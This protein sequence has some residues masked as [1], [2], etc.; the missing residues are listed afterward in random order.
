MHAA[1]IEPLVS[2]NGD[3]DRHDQHQQSEFLPA[4]SQMNCMNNEQLDIIGRR[5]R[6]EAMKV[7]NSVHIDKAWCDSAQDCCNH[8]KA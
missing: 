4:T 7:D 5:C 6:K 8:L 3:Q 2:F 1:E